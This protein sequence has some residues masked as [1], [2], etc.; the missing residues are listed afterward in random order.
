MYNRLQSL[1]RVNTFSKVWHND[2]F[3]MYVVGID[4]FWV[5]ANPNHSSHGIPI[6]FDEFTFSIVSSFYPVWFNLILMPLIYSSIENLR[7]DQ[8]KTYHPISWLSNAWNLIQTHAHT[9]S[10][11]KKCSNKVECMQCLDHTHHTHTKETIQFT[12]IYNAYNFLL[13]L[14]PVNLLFNSA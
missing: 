7:K 8:I 13:F 4:V 11:S 14:V 12:T 10:C 9:N 3:T 5:L 2:Y 6:R 1:W